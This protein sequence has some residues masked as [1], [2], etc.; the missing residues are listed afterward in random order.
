[1][2]IYN[3]ISVRAW[4]RIYRNIFFLEELFEDDS[5]RESGERE[6]ERE[7]EIERFIERKEQRESEN[8]IAF[9]L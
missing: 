5:D 8:I 6:K 4:E 1:M 3:T 7:R 2:T 9:I